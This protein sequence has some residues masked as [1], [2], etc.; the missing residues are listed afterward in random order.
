MKVLF[1]VTN[2]IAGG[3]ETM[4]TEVALR[5]KRDGHEVTV[6]SLTGDAPLGARLR[7]AD[8]PV[9]AL[10]LSF[11]YPDPRAVFRIAGLMRSFRPDLVQT[12]MYHSDLLGGLATLLAGRPPLVWAIHHTAADPETLAPRTRWVLRLNA[13]LSNWLPNQIICCAESARTT[14]I[15]AGYRA[16]KMIVI[17]NGVDVNRFQPQPTA[18]SD[19]RRELSLAP[20]TFLVGLCARFHPTKDHGTFIKAASLFHRD[21]PDAHFILTG[22]E[23]NENNPALTKLLDEAGIRAHC[24]LLGQRADLPRLL[25]ALD[26]LVSSSRSEALSLIIVEA[27]ACSV[28]CVVTDV[29]DSALIVGESGRVVPAGDPP[30][31]AAALQTLRASRLNELGMQARQRVE[32]LYN[33][34]LVTARYWKTYEEISGQ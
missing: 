34:D 8:I 11:R 5:G 6:I 4:M 9:H 23:V 3:A 30:A 13:W 32:S 16:D 27:M 12:W 15:A 2:L 10:G 20:E 31:M 18:R 28:P 33:L 14:H 19:V 24:H 21:N 29:G 17:P 25:P 1:V 22:T 26:V 7:E